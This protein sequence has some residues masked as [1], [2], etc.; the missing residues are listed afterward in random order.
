MACKGRNFIREA[1]H[2]FS[3][4]SHASSERIQ[5]VCSNSS[6]HVVLLAVSLFMACSVS[7]RSKKNKYINYI[8]DQN[9][10]ITETLSTISFW[11]KTEIFCIGFRYKGKVGNPEQPRSCNV[12]INIYFRKVLI[13]G[14]Q[15]KA[16]IC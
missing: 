1:A 3:R 8:F 12:S 4:G 9:K 16:K 13:S 2:F 11:S 15:F 10:N 14:R 5:F 7:E 6:T